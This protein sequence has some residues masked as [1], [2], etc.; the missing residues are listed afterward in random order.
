VTD[1]SGAA[2]VVACGLEV[3]VIDEG[4]EHLEGGSA[5]VV[6]WRAGDD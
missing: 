5:G 4:V 2:A 3:E 6:A 1:E